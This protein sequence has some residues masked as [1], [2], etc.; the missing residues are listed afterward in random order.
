[1]GYLSDWANDQFAEV[2]GKN[3]FYDEFGEVFFPRAD[4]PLA[5]SLSSEMGASE[6][7][8]LARESMAKV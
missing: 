2:S 8:A 3:R 7:L 4:G 6:V 5:D 1:M